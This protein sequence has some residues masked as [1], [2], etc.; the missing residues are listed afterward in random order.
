MPLI[1]LIQEQRLA[2]R[3]DEMRARTYL[4]AFAVIAGVSIF[5]ALGFYI[6]T[7]STRG[8]ESRLRFE[9]QEI[10]PLTAQ[11]DEVTNLD[12]QLEP[13]VETLQK[14]QQITQHRTT[15]G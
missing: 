7:E 2:I 3:R 15:Y 13:R 12:S 11:I 4:Y 9:L 8:E 5:S 1:N 6:D 10:K 14:A